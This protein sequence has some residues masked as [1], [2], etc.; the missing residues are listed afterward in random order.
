MLIELC[1]E[2]D[3]FSHNAAY[4]VTKFRML[5]YMCLEISARYRIITS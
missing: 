5:Q 1:E 4:A 2:H 3:G